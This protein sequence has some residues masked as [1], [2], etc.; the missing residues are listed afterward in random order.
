MTN[1]L[2]APNVLPF[3]AP[4][5]NLIRPE[6]FSPALEVA[7]R[8]HREAVAAIA[9]NPAP[10]DFDNTL[11]ALER[12]SFVLDR[13]VNLF[14]HYAATLSDATLQEIERELSPR[15]SRHQS[16]IF[17]MPG[18][19]ERIAAVHATCDTLPEEPR[20]LVEEQYRWFTRAGAALAP[21]QKEQLAELKSR[22]ATGQTEFEQKLLK[23]TE[24]TFFLLDAADL[25]GLPPYLREAAAA[26]AARRGHPEKFAI[27]INRSSAK[28]FI[29]FSARRDLR[30]K[31][32]SR[33]AAR[34]TG[35]YDTSAI[36]RE[37]VSL[38]QKIARLLGYPD[39]A[40]FAL[41]DSMA[42]TPEAARGLLQD[43]WTPALAK[44][45]TE[46]EELQA[47]AHACG[48]N[49]PLTPWDWD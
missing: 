17:H 39:Y 47:E 1:P 44:L 33:F 4:P 26:E 35:A 32:Y 12:S 13:I 6:H 37:I 8:N 25:D 36:L 18:L 30:E 14:H 31:I 2:L 11:A 38:R 48:Q 10:A 49:D 5:F 21:A 7:F 45:R 19:F 43:I 40:R 42:K 28:E 22:L 15:L 9:N 34:G 16:D 29:R 20:R 24:A 23:E 46:R 3:G 27:G 41:E